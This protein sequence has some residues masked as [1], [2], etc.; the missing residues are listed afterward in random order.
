M[1]TLI[2]FFLNICSAAQIR[3]LL[4]LFR[5]CRLTTVLY[6]AFDFNGAEQITLDEMV[7]LFQAANDPCFFFHLIFYRLAQVIL[8]LTAFNGLVT[9][10]GVGRRPTD[11]EMEQIT[12]SAFKRVG[13]A[14]T[15]Y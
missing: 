8:M 6:D 7:K 9:M 10:T 2:V 11:D 5:L 14:I 12:V 15:Y 3:F 13:E 1:R 4:I